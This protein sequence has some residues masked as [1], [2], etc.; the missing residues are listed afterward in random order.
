[1]HVGLYLKASG[2]TI[3][4][5]QTGTLSVILVSSDFTVFLIYSDIFFSLRRSLHHNIFFPHSFFINSALR[6]RKVL[7]IKLKKTD[8]SVEMEDLEEE[9]LEKVI[10]EFQI[11]FT[12]NEK[13][14]RFTQRKSL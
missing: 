7:K 2:S 4:A 5:V 10:P 11:I 9:I 14:K 6:E 1:M 13:N 3:I 8:P 12:Y